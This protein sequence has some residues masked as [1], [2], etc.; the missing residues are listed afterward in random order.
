MNPHAGA[1]SRH[2][3]VDAIAA[4][5]R[6]GNFDVRVCTDLQELSSL[7]TESVVD[8]AIRVV[9]AVGGDGTAAVVRN[10]V[11]LEVPLLAVPMGT[12]NLLGR[13]LE[14]ETDAASVCDVV[15][16]G[17]VVDLDLARADNR[18]FLLM[19]SAGF[20]AEV[21]RSLH[22]N[23]RGNI[24]HGSYLLPMMKSMAGYRYP[25]MQLQYD[26]TRPDDVGVRRCRWLFGFNLPLYAL[27]LPI[28]PK[29]IATDGLLDLCT[30][31]RGAVWS[32]ARYLW[33][34]VQR[35]HH[36][37]TDATMSRTR[38]FRLEAAEGATI[39][40]QLDGDY[41]GSLPVEVEV[42]PGQLRLLVSPGAARKLKFEVPADL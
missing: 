20:D 25:E 33:H 16:N 18:Y 29:A 10:H 28:A 15:E 21:V 14:Q 12:E 35:G 31:E 36:N 2:E 32:V 13:F 22:E 24:R 3:H 30:F 4:S 26:T 6:A 42:L 19:I 7:A 40:Y 17:V 41:A 34:I 8:G 23:R 11:P 27:G 5:L 38:R 37:L 39:P 1:R 9:L